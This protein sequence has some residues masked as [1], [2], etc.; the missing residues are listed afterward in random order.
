MMIKGYHAAIESMYSKIRERNQAELNERRKNIASH[1]PVIL[2]VENRIGKMC[3]NLALNSMKNGAAEEDFQRLKKQ[4]I[5]LKAQ[6]IELLVTYGYPEDYLDLLYNCPKCKDTGYLVTEKCKCY[7]QKLIQLYYKNSDLE[8][9]ILANNFNTFD[10]GYFPSKKIGDEKYSPRKN[11]EVIVSKIREDYLP[12][13][14]KHNDNL[15]FYGNSGTGKTFLSHCIAKEVLDKGQL[16]VYRT[17]DLLIKNL[18]DIRYKENEQLEDLL[19][20]CDLL[21][22]DDLGAEHL[23]DYAVTDLFQVL[24]RKLLLRKKMLI[25]TNLTLEQLYKTYSERFTSRLFGNFIVFK[26]YSEDIRVHKNLLSI[27][28][29]L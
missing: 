21:I 9:A 8:D 13:F 24:N 1:H 27:R 28:Q 18:R 20:N 17:T 10:F 5:E 19:V 25:S 6:K 15:M 7:K 4:I 2:D 3:L 16:V 29:S 26:F 22:I 14:H 23:N 12:N 11:M